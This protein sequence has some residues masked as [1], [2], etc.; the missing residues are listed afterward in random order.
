MTF[1]I[2]QISKLTVN[3]L[4]KHLSSYCTNLMWYFLLTILLEDRICNSYLCECCWNL[5]LHLWRTQWT[6]VLLT[7]VVAATTV[8][9]GLAAAAPSLVNSRHR[10]SVPRD[11]GWTGMERHAIV[12]WN[13]SLSLSLL[14]ALSLPP[15]LSLSLSLISWFFLYHF[16][17]ISTCLHIHITLIPYVH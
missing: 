11:I 9:L 14:V 16:T 6:P 4:P 1:R 3:L 5:S 10:V 12:V 7:M 8:S 13:I 15:S 2:Q 17:T